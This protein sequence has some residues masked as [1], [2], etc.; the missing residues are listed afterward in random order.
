[1]K[2]SEFNRTSSWPYM[3]ITICLF[4][5]VALAVR[6]W[7]SP[8]SSSFWLSETYATRTVNKDVAKYGTAQ[9]REQRS[10]AGVRLYDLADLSSY[11]VPPSPATLRPA[12]TK[13]VAAELPSTETRPFTAEF[14]PKF[15]DAPQI[16]TEIEATLTPIRLPPLPRASEATSPVD[17]ASSGESINVV[18]DAPTLTEPDVALP[19]SNLSEPP[20][21]APNIWPVPRAL[22]D[23]LTEFATNGSDHPLR[24]WAAAVELQIATLVSAE[25]LD[26]A[27]A[28]AAIARLEQLHQEC[29]A[30][31]SKESLAK[32]SQL[33]AIQDMRA[34]MLRTAHALKRRLAIWKQLNGTAAKPIYA[35]IETRSDSDVSKHIRA[36]EQCLSELHNDDEWRRYL[37]LHE[38]RCTLTSQ[39]PQAAHERACLARRILARI[40]APHLNDKQRAVLTEKPFQEL[41]DVLRQCA[42]EPVDYVALLEHIEKYEVEPNACSAIKVAESYQALRWSPDADLK[43][44]GDEIDAQFR[45]ANV[46]VAVT[47]TLLNRLLPA[48]DVLDAQVDDNILG[49]RIRGM[50]RTYSQLR[51]VLIPDRFQWRL[52]LEA[53]GEVASETTASK[54]PA[55]FF[56]EGISNYFARK[57]LSVGRG[58][59]RTRGAETNA[60]ME[61]ELKGVETDFDWMPLFGHFARSIAIQQHHQSYPTAQRIAEN[62]V[63]SRASQV[64]DQEV[65]N[66]LQQVEIDFEKKLLTPLRELNLK[67]TAVEMET[68]SDRLIVRYRL[69]GDRQVGSNTPRPQAPSDSLLSVQLHESALN[70]TLESLNIAGR[71]ADL[72]AFASELSRTFDKKISPA[73]IEDVPENVTIQFAEEDPIRVRCENGRITLTLKVAELESAEGSVWRNFEVLVHYKPAPVGLQANLIRDGIIE[74][75]GEKLGARGRLPLRLIFSKI[76]AQGRSL[77]VIPG[78]LAINP[79]MKDLQ[80]NQFVISDGWVGVAV[81]PD[82]KNPTAQVAVTQR[83]TPPVQAAAPRYSQP[84]HSAAQPNRIRRR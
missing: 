43:K 16:E 21:T 45:N 70:N 52:D 47:S 2:S 71:R 1:M 8:H 63:A 22:M 75:A 50:S 42:S 64:F 13:H 65:Q 57:N 30:I 29:L 49:A 39:A 78:K 76:F 69:A 68:T 62:Q 18:V 28:T 5:L 51:V 32:G 55:K 73:F 77:N 44:L 26:A 14:A 66:R 12:V 58:G 11:P 3:G 27:E 36:V 37:L 35:S 31:A 34:T 54:G 56:S 23:R 24:E 19:Q 41:Q 60:A 38:L 9:R 15:A 40:S 84:V 20:V 10:N 80:V 74:V 6:V 82:R 33:K 61:N 72:R 79:M 46:R 53:N 25:S 7:R 4:V 83:F 81:G 17:P 67:P 48:P 59:V